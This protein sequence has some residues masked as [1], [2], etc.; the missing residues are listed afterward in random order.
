MKELFGQYGRVTVSHSATGSFHI[1]CY[2]NQTFNFL[3]LKDSIPQWVK[4]NRHTFS[5]FI[6]GYT[7]AEGNFILNQKR[8]RF[9]IDSYDFKILD[10]IKDF[11]IMSGVGVRF[12]RIAQK[13]GERGRGKKWNNDLWR[14]NVNE[15][16]SLKKFIRFIWPYLR[17]EKRRADAGVVLENVNSRI[18]NET[19][20]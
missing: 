1:N 11:L 20:R 10:G 12:R 17:H 9:K 13:G 6:A 8:G 14:L 15:A 4:K 19:T 7:D 16:R 2:L 5:A 3:F 18:S